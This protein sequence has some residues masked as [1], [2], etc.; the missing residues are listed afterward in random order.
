MSKNE[1][2][3][4][5]CTECGANMYVDKNDSEFYE[6]ENEECGFYIHEEYF[7]DEINEDYEEFYDEDNAISE[8]CGACGGPYP[9]CMT[10]CELF[11]E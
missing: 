8:G 7:R 1:E 2:I 4:Y 5:E 6:C 9:H 11:D 3:K 10:S